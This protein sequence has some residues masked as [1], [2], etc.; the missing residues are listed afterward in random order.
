M[1]YRYIYTEKIFNLEK[2]LF[3]LNEEMLTEFNDIKQLF[4]M[5]LFPS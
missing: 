2:F 1:N 5:F 3:K 4:F